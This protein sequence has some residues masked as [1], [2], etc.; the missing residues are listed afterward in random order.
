MSRE[1]PHEAPTR[2]TTRG[3]RDACRPRRPGQ[4]RAGG[5][6]RPA[7]RALSLRYSASQV[8]ARTAACTHHRSAA[9]WS[10]ERRPHTPRARPRTRTSIATL[11]SIDPL[12][13]R[14]SDVGV[15]DAM[16]PSPLRRQADLPKPGS[17]CYAP[18]NAALLATHR[19]PV[20]SSCMKSLASLNAVGLPLK[21]GLVQALPLSSCRP[22]VLVV[23]HHSHTLP[24]RS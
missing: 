22:G 11:Q 20:S 5:R 15:R 21:K 9:H 7:A 18:R 6:V 8:A 24:T 12:K 14:G 19:K 10:G 23:R 17:G 13:R 1:S 3:N 16:D 2:T 4:G